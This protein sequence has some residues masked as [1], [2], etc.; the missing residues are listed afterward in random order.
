MLRSKDLQETLKRLLVNMY[1]YKEGDMPFN[2]LIDNEYYESKRILITP[3]FMDYN[4]KGLV[5]SSDKKVEEFHTCY[6]KYYK[7]LEFLSITSFNNA[8]ILFPEYRTIILY[9]VNLYN[10]FV[11][12]I[13]VTAKDWVKTVLRLNQYTILIKANSLAKS[14]NGKVKGLSR[15]ELGFISDSLIPIYIRMDTE[16]LEGDNDFD[17]YIAEKFK[18]ACAVVD[19]LMLSNV[20]LQQDNDVYFGGYKCYKNQNTMSKTCYVF[21]KDLIAKGF[22]TISSFYNYLFDRVNSMEESEIENIMDSVKP[23]VDLMIKD[24]D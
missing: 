15:K 11:N 6:E 14:Q 16:R 5:T 3:L 13:Y 22:P 12:K 21:K 19:H 17:K 24:V 4:I 8:C 2:I 20:P 23:V 7:Y 18:K 10:N 9:T 1:E